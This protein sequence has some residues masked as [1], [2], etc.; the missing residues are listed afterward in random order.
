MLQK[1]FLRRIEAAESNNDDDDVGLSFMLMVESARRGEKQLVGFVQLGLLPPPPGFPTD[2]NA[3]TTDQD[4][5]IWNG[6]PLEI[7]ERAPDVPYIANLCVL[8]SCRKTG[9]GKKM[10][11]ISLRWLNKRDKG[12]SNAFIA[13]DSDNFLAKRFYERIG[14]IWIAPP[15]DGSTKLVA[16]KRDY[17][18]YPLSS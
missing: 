8:P 10:V 11:D 14:F 16:A 3:T 1:S 13:V 2:K 4:P 9:M 18:F 6:I 15:D 12:F 7:L 5:A 17:Y